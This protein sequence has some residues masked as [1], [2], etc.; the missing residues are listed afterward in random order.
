MAAW[1]PP[2]P[3]AEG[4]CQ[5]LHRAAAPRRRLHARRGR[6][7]PPGDHGARVAPHCA[8]LAGRRQP[9]HLRPRGA[10]GAGRGAVRAGQ[11]AVCGQ[12]RVQCWVCGRLWERG[13]RIEGM[14][15]PPTRPL[16]HPSASPPRRCREV[17]A[18]SR[19]RVNMRRIQ[20]ALVG[21]R[22]CKRTFDAIKVGRQ[23]GQAL[24]HDAWR[25]QD[26]A[27]PLHTHDPPAVPPFSPPPPADVEGSAAQH[28]GHGRHLLHLLLP[29]PGHP[30]PA[31]L[32]CAGHAGGAAW[33]C[34]CAGHAAAVAG[35]LQPPAAFLLA[36]AIPHSSPHMPHTPHPRHACAHGAG[37]AGH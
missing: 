31:G 1:L 32:A 27:T 21:V 17:F 30:R 24:L 15:L 35:R 11:G 34:G 36:I 12:R 28:S 4:A 8:A 3:Q 26:G 16:P 33:R 6:Q 9:C 18:M 22:R 7:R 10:G 2:P 20:M 25:R 14:L 29:P 19:A 23:G 5:G 37:S 13:M